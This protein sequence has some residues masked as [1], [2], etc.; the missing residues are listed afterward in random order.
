MTQGY[1]YILQSLNNQSY[2]IGSTKNVLR[3]LEQHNSGNVKST[4][5]RRPYK[6]VFQQK[7]ANIGIT[8]Q[9]ERRIKDW[10]RK[11]FIKKIIKDNYIK[12]RPLSSVVEQ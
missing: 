1:V 8:R 10:K 12:S 3:R 11:D 4:K 9:I 5:S 2:Y 6:L 7:F